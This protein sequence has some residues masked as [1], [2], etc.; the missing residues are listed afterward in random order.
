MST[1]GGH[2]LSRI[3]EKGLNERHLKPGACNTTSSLH[4]LTSQMSQT[5]F[6]TKT[7]FGSNNLTTDNVLA[8]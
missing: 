3:I 5:L 2:K 4:N 1:S 6:Q 7:A 8:G